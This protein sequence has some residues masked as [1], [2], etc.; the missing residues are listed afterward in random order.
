MQRYG[1]LMREVAEEEI[2]SWPVG[3]P[4]ELAPRMQGVTLEIIIRAVFGVREEARK[5]RLR[6][7]LGKL[8]EMLT[9]PLSFLATLAVG[10]DRATNTPMF[11]R[12]LARADAVIYEEIAARRTAGDLT[13][14][15]D[16]LSLLLQATDEDGNPMSDV[17]LR[18]ELLTLLVAG[19][20]T[21]ATALSWAFE[22]TLRTPG[23]YERLRDEALAGDTAYADAVVHETLRLRPVV[24]IVLRKLQAD[25]TIAGR[26]LP[27]G[28]TVVPSIIMVHRRAETYP[29]PHAFRPERFVG[30][31]PGTYTWIPF[32][33]GVRR[34]LGAAFAM[35]EMQVVLQ[36]VVRSVRLRPG[37]DR[38]ERVKRR[39]ITLAPAEGGT[40][41]REP[42]AAPE[43]LTV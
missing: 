42:A 34:C 2:A 12:P 21:T 36:A 23:A 37:S 32:G 39:A 10:V 18:D 14:R 26:D 43:P 8:L 33:G 16:I 31:K 19:H 40:V 38:P 24:P 17:E 28:T 27:R 30:V 4:L 3:T 22:R 35:Y 6:E 25:M 15:D 41:I 7:A 11:R 20:E 29:E 13:E 5:D 1:E 9:D